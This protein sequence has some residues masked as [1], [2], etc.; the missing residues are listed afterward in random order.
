MGKFQ[1]PSVKQGLIC[2][3]VLSSLRA[4]ILNRRYQPGEHLVETELARQ[5]GTS[6]GPIR[7]AIKEL[8][9][10][11][12]VVIQP[13]KGGV[14]ATFSA[15]DI[16]EISELRILV[17]GH[18][19]RLAS[20]NATAE[21]LELL[22]AKYD[23]M[24]SLAD[25]GDLRRLVEKDIDFHREVCRLSGNGRLLKLWTSLASQIRLFLVMFDQVYFTPQYIV[26]THRPIL[27]AMYRRDH[28]AAEEE[29]KR[30]LAEAA[31]TIVQGMRNTEQAPTEQ[32]PKSPVA[33]QTL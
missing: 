17:E 14:V 33:G 1:L 21:D 31:E 25:A 6:R 11:G 7:D 12:L 32:E 28:A 9:Q 19:T 15:Q 23:E 8:A 4:A 20:Q 2:D 16:L 27:E 10:E 3:D 29:I 13:H 26:E 18:A 24:Q 22:Q 5:Y 30:H